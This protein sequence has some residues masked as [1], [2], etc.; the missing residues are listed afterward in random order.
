M[1]TAAL[2]GQSDMLGDAL[3]ATDVVETASSIGDTAVGPFEMVF[4]GLRTGDCRGGGEGIGEGSGGLPLGLSLSLLQFVS[5]RSETMSSRLVETHVNLGACFVTS[6][7][8]LPS[9]PFF[10]SFLEAVVE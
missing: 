8:T 5:H 6:G 9:L 4:V 2:C 1:L 10:L 3:V 7:R